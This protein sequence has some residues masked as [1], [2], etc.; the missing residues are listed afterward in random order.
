MTFKFTLYSVNIYKLKEIILF[1]LF[2]KI[3]GITTR[4]VNVIVSTYSLSNQQKQSLNQC[5]F[6][7]LK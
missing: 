1:H 2:R 3:V 7:A 4:Y 5:H 6:L